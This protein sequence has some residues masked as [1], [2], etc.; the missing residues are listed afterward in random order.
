VNEPFTDVAIAPPDVGGLVNENVPVISL[1]VD[2]VMVSV[3]F[4]LP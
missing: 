4:A 3:P 2:V 1:G